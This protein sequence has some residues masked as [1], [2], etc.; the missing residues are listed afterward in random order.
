MSRAPPPI[1]VKDMTSD[2]LDAE[3]ARILK[4]LTVQ[5][6]VAQLALHVAE[7][8]ANRFKALRRATDRHPR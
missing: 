5:E 4:R 2:Q 7:F 8:E 1:A 3:L 6:R